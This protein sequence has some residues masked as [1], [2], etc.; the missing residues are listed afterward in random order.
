MD[1]VSVAD[2]EAPLGVPFLGSLIQGRVGLDCMSY[3]SS[4]NLIRVR[5]RD[6]DRVRVTAMASV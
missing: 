6:T 3:V 4:S 5:D 2:L 1:D